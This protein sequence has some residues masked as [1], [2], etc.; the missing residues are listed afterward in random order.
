MLIWKKWEGT[1]EDWDKT[2]LRFPDYNI[3]QSFAWGEHRRRFGW[4]PV[5][6]IAESGGEIVCTA[7][8]LLRHLPLG[9][10][11]AWIPGGPCGEPALWAPS[12]LESLGS[13]LGSQLLYCRINDMRAECPS[14]IH[15]MDRSWNRP[16]FLLHTGLSMAYNPSSPESARL[17]RTSKNWGRNLRRAQKQGNSVTLWESPNPAEMHRVYREMQDYKSLGEQYSEAALSSL[18]KNFGSRCV[19]VRCTDSSGNLL[20]FRGALFWGARGW[21]IFAAT[22]P[23][24]RKV[25]ASH[26][27]FWELLN[28]CEKLGVK[29]YDMSGIDPIKGKGVYD[30][31]KGTGADEL[32]FL[33][34]WDAATFPLL[35]RVANFIVKWRIRGA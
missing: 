7:Q 35:R 32:K 10:N 1:D 30:F 2:Q 6:I 12:L 34:E 25:Y 31:K 22:T 3:Y 20:A 26:A 21:D 15:V 5:R 28:Q 23:A 18:I 17:E 16:E 14:D 24:G 11:F 33:G 4:Q 9:I 29:W 13:I 8:V 27:V 19:L